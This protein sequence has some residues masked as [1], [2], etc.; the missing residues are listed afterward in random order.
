MLRAACN[1]A[2]W[3]ARGYPG[4]SDFAKEIVHPSDTQHESQKIMKRTQILHGELVLKRET[5]L[6]QQAQG[7]GSVHNVINIQE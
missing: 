2:C 6:M 4:F 3:H 7:R 1:P 5:N